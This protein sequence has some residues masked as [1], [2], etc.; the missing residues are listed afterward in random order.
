M[1][2]ALRDYPSGVTIGSSHC[3]ADEKDDVLL[4]FKFEVL[5][6]DSCVCFYTY[7]L[8]L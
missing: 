5:H 3:I 7:L 1:I 6:A 4:T 2:G 8:R